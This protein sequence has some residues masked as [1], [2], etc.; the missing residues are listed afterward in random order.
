[1]CH[2][3]SSAVLRIWL[4]AISTLY[5]SSVTSSGRIRTRLSRQSL[6][7]LGGEAL[8][9]GHLTVALLRQDMELSRLLDMIEVRSNLA[10]SFIEVYCAAVIRLSSHK[11]HELGVAV[12]HVVPHLTL[13]LLVDVREEPPSALDLR[14]LDALELQRGE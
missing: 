14:V 13:E 1:M 3:R 11:F 6:R 12:G 4:S 10:F 2:I 5:S 9:V 8:V 7:W